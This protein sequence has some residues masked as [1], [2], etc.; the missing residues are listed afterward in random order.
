MGDTYR[1]VPP[2]CFT[3]FTSADA[4]KIEF[5]FS[6]A[7][8]AKKSISFLRVCG[9]EFCEAPRD[10]HFRQNPGLHLIANHILI[11]VSQSCIMNKDV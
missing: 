1:Q 10:E 7:K 9:H 6:P 8:P 11:T 5:V 3:E 2:I 4:N